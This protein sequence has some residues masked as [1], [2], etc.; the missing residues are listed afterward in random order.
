MHD[1]LQKALKKLRLSGLAQTLDVRLQEAQVIHV[2]LG[3]TGSDLLALTEHRRQLQSLEVVLEQYG[4]FRLA[5]TAPPTNN[6]S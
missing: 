3:T 6:S 1:T 4:G 2:L 5:H